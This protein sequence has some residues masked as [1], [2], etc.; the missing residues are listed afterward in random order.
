FIVVLQG[1]PPRR[2]GQ[3]VALQR[4]E[5]LDGGLDQRVGGHRAVARHLVER[6]PQVLGQGDVL[7]RSHQLPLRLSCQTERTSL[8]VSHLNSACRSSYCPSA[9]CASGTGTS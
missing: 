7:L 9:M 6:A 5:L 8:S 1:G 3:L 2:R 4:D